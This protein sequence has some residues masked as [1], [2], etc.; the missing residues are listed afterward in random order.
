[1]LQY[2]LFYRY[3]EWAAPTMLGRLVQR[4]EA[5]WEAV[6][7]GFSATEP[8]FVAYSAHCGGRWLEWDDIQVAD[9]SSL[10]SATHPL[11]AVAEGSHANYDDS[12]NRRPPD[13]ATCMGME[14][15]AFEALTYV[16]GI[17]DVTG[18]HYR[19]LPTDV[20]LVDGR[21]PPMS[22]PGTWGGN[23]HTRLRNARSFQI[24]E[25]GAG[26]KTPTLQPL[27][28]D[29]ITTIFCSEQ[30]RPRKCDKGI[31]PPADR[32]LIAVLDEL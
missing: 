32:G 26:P 7:I 11:V 22:F 13:W 9:D 12:H 25:E 5:D 14:G 1:L 29:P 10:S 3:D 21:D 23:D 17:E 27:W 16:W 28:I 31:R 30:W 8:L 15:S 18:D 24:G 2:W 4:H 6:T 19:L 20:R